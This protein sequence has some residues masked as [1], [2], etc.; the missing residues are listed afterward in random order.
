MELTH[1]TQCNEQHSLAMMSVADQMHVTAIQ[2]TSMAILGGLVRNHF[3]KRGRGRPRHNSEVARIKNGLRAMVR[4]S[5]MSV[6]PEQE[7][8]LLTQML[9]RSLF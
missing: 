7:L 5:G 6:T 1:T 9:N 3:G 4:A 2:D 8:A